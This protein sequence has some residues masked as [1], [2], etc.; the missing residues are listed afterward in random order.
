MNRKISIGSWAYAIG[1]Y[2]SKPVPLDEVAKRLGELKFDGIEL[3]GFKPHAHPD[4]YPTKADRQK[5]MDML[6]GNGLGVSAYVPDLWGFPFAEGD[7]AVVKQYDDA[8]DQGVE[9]ATD[10]G[11]KMLRLDCVTASPFPDALDYEETW[12]RVVDTFKKCARKAADVGANVTWEFEPGFIFNKPSE[13][14][15]MVEDVGEDNFGVLLDTCHVQ[16]C[17]VVGAKQY[18]E[19]E[20]LD[21]G[22]L[23]FIEMLAG[24]IN[25][26]HI[27]D[28]DNTLHDDDTSTHAP[29]GQ[30]VID[31]HKVVPAIEAAGYSSGW[32][33]IDLCFWDNAWDVTADCKQYVDKL[34]AE[35]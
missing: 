5:L 2:E 21:G 30:G 17:A 32:W 27:I 23:E 33:P 26:V 28:S 34:F 22:V 1:P 19:K 9:F 7:P 14:K 20:T 25:H 4:L 13:I 10:C 15:K 12:Q 11:I 18:G 29:F 31:F 16:M 8:F 35:I 3:G 24:K 6:A